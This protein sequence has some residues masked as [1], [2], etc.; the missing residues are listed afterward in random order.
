ML[1]Q[2]IIC[3]SCDQ[4]YIVLSDNSEVAYCPFCGDAVETEYERGELEMGSDDE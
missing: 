3:P 1:K 4:Q 2:E